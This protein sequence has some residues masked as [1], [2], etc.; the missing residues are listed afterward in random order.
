MNLRNY[1]LNYDEALNI[2]AGGLQFFESA[3][4]GFCPFLLSRGSM[5]VPTAK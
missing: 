4:T 3:F 1:N 5:A 2:E